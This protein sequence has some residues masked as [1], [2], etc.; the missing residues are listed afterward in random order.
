M[1]QRIEE[2]EVLN[3]ENKLLI[4]HKAL[5]VTIK[6]DNETTI[7]N[8]NK[9]KDTGYFRNKFSGKE[10][11]EI[12]ERVENSIIERQMDMDENEENN[13]EIISET[14]KK[15]IKLKNVITKEITE[16]KQELRVKNNTTTN[17]KKEYNLN[18]KEMSDCDRVKIKLKIIKEI[19]QCW[20]KWSKLVME[21]N[22]FNIETR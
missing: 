15:W 9:G 1:L 12:A 20:K 18:I 2:H 14:D 21:K 22:E 6:I 19:E 8:N 16:M 3:V 4:D 17:T 11:E 7:S 10:W 5:T 13:E